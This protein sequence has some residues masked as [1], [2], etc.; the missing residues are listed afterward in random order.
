ML[1]IMDQNGTVKIV[2][3]TEVQTRRDNKNF[4]VAPDSNGNDMKIGDAMKETAGEVSQPLLML[5]NRQNRTG[6]VISI[7]RSIFVWLFNRDIPENY[8]VFVARHS[9]LLSVTP[10]AANDFSKLNPA[11]QSQLPYGGASLMPPPQTTQNRNR[12]VNT[13]VVVVKGTQKGLMGVIKDIQGEKARVEM[14]TNNKVL[15]LDIT[16]LKRKE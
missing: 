16:S 10:K 4:A 14:A 1:R 12:L 15:T 8:G 6:E 5:A 9:S 3:P 11:L 7:F 2:S 13:L